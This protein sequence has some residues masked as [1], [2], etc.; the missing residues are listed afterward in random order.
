ML[1][2]GP[3]PLYLGLGG[4]GRVSHEQHGIGGYGPRRRS[5]F[6]YRAELAEERGLRLLL[7]AA[8]NRRAAGCD[9][10]KHE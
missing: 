3:T 5:V 1:C 4:F 10:G 7:L 6:A 8:V 9:N 2:S